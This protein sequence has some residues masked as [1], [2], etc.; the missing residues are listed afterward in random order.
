METQKYCVYNQTRESFLSLGVTAADAT[1]NRLRELIEKL[2]SQADTGL[3][4]TPFRG[5]PPAHGISPIDLVYLDSEYRVIQEVESFPTSTVDFSMEN[6]ASALILPAHTIYSSQ[7][8][9][10]DQL[11][12]CI[13]SDMERR[14]EH[15]STSFTPSASSSSVVSST[16]KHS[17]GSAFDASSSRSS[18]GE[19]MFQRS[20]AM[21]SF[22]PRSGKPGT[23][24]T[25]LQNWL[26]SD[27]RKSPRQP[28]PGLVA[29]YWTGSTPRAYQIADISSSGFY[30]LTEE[31]WF[32]GTM[33]LMTLQRTDSSGK[34]LD[35]SIAVQSRVVRWGVDGLGLAFVVSRS[36]DPASG[37]SMRENG[38]D[39]KTLERFL[40]RLKDST[41]VES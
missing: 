17:H 16:E 20:E 22:E 24:K 38:V 13:A 9:P 23:L 1:A 40:A 5:L 6:A 27:R 7:T 11:V 31:R 10:G 32:P 18:R 39:K 36:I 30:L 41:L 26:S 3:W 15:L 29:Y 4:M 8:Q 28:L 33:V 37:D 19:T 21:N 14:L 2:A 35:D 25:W 34:N 12:I